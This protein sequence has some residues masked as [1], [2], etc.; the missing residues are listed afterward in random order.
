MTKAPRMR[1]PPVDHKL[2][3]RWGWGAEELERQIEL[4][5]EALIRGQQANPGATA[6]QLRKHFFAAVMRMVDRIECPWRQEM[7]M[8]QAHW[9]WEHY[10]PEVR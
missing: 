7:I 5:P 2:W 4:F 9:L 3:Q 1:R 8:S 6:W 10:G